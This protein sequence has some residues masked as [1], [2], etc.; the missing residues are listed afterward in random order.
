MILLPLPLQPLLGPVHQ[1]LSEWRQ[2]QRSARH[3]FLLQLLL[4]VNRASLG[5]EGDF[6]SLLSPLSR[7]VHQSWQ[8]F[9]QSWTTSA[10]TDSNT[11]SDQHQMLCGPP[12]PL[13]THYP[14]ISTA[15][16]QQGWELCSKASSHHVQVLNAQL[17][18]AAPA[19]LKL[20]RYRPLSFCL[21]SISLNLGKASTSGKI[22]AGV[23]E[24]RDMQMLQIL[25]EQMP[26][27]HCLLL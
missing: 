25:E 7:Q 21:L 11:A 26:A 4:P 27:A 12:L 3:K 5:Y 18:C 6:S 19:T 9:I 1:G 23:P 13:R 15:T 2:K 10:T 16:A 8:T 14:Q 22:S 24:K 20:T 17:N